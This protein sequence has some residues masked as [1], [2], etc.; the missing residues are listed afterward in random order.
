MGNDGRVRAGGYRG[1]SVLGYACTVVKGRVVVLE[2]GIER[3]E[4][5]KGIAADT[6]LEFLTRGRTKARAGQRIWWYLDRDLQY[7][8]RRLSAK[9]W[10]MLHDAIPVHWHGYVITYLAG[11]SVT[12]KREG[13]HG[14][15]YYTPASLWPD[16]LRS[17]SKQWNTLLPAGSVGD[18]VAA[19]GVVCAIR[20]RMENVLSLPGGSRPTSPG[21]FAALILRYAK[22]ARAYP[23]DRELSSKAGLYRALSIGY[24][25][26]RSEVLRLGGFDR[27]LW[28]Y[29][30]HSA[31]PWAMAHCPM[32]TVDGWR[33]VSKYDPTLPFALWHVKWSL[34]EREYQRPGPL[35][36]RRNDGS[37]CYP[38]EGESWVWAPELSHARRLYGPRHVRVLAG[39]SYPCSGPTPLR[40]TILRLYKLRRVLDARGD[41]TGQVLKAVLVAAYGKL[42]QA[43]GYAEW[44]NLPWAGWI[45]SLIRA[46]L[47]KVGEKHEDHIIAYTVDGL[48]TDTRLD[49][50][51]MDRLGG[52]S[53]SR[54][55]GGTIV[56]PGLY[57]LVCEDGTVELATRGFRGSPEW[58]RRLI[59]V[60]NE[61]GRVRVKRQLL[62]T[63][64]LHRLMPLET[65]KKLLEQIGLDI[66]L[67]PYSQSHRWYDAATTM[68]HTPGTWPITDWERENRG[69]LMLRGYPRMSHGHR[70]GEDIETRAAAIAEAVRL[71]GE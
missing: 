4:N 32:F 34:P 66:S 16:G 36:W 15:R 20:E 29:D 56:A 70:A 6:A 49:V 18:S 64:Q 61:G 43:E 21:S 57:R 19:E 55:T 54:Y 35:P 42:A 11:H 22:A 53:E 68:S 30:I 46:R 38:A 28:R 51:C 41:P 67:D 44:R 2:S 59:H 48:I 12:F 17:A 25:G 40:S 8:F 5:P 7:L 23:N 31:Y 62:V 47:L 65:H 60:L 71:V 50:E 37:L 10:R 1:D 9:A 58:F 69:S 39:V 24:V 27:P 13:K 26:G 63:H 14:Y 52:W 45:T 3:I 33:E